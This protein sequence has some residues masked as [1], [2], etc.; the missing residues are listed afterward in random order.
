M[1]GTGQGK[2]NNGSG[3][4]RFDCS[5]RRRERGERRYH[6]NANDVGDSSKDEMAAARSFYPFENFG[7]CSLTHSL[8]FHPAD[9][10][11]LTTIP[12][13]LCRFNP[14]FIYLLS[15]SPSPTTFACFLSLLQFFCLPTGRLVKFCWAGK[16]K[17]NRLPLTV[18]LLF[19]PKL[20]LIT[21]VLLLFLF[22]S[23]ADCDVM[24]RLWLMLLFSS[25]RCSFFRS[26][27]F[28]AVAVAAAF[29]LVSFVGQCSG[30]GTS[31]PP[32]HTKGG[33]LN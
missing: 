26:L 27:M 11:H 15:G 33:K 23:S 28:A 32:P 4:S 2:A 29:N 17:F 16:I 8:T 22:L 25:F 7:I 5:P 19:V 1:V 14:L 13:S 30:S 3:C 12:L 6:V 20:I 18:C 31:P 9:L 10:V 21:A 24:W